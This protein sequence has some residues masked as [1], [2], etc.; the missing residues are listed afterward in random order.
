MQRLM[1]IGFL[2]A[3]CGSSGDDGGGGEHQMDVD[4]GMQPQGGQ[5]VVECR[6]TVQSGAPSNCPK[7]DCDDSG[8]D[9]CTAYASWVAGDANGLCNPG[10]TGTYGLLFSDG[11]LSNQFYEVIQCT[12]GT[13]KQHPCASGFTTVS[14]GYDGQPGYMCL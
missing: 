13:P 3:G 1:L 11:T 12:N 2:V 9:A 4:G 5:H 10:E 6:G 7:G 8:G 14:S